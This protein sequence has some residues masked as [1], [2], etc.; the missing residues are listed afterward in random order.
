MRRSD[1][2][3]QNLCCRTRLFWKT[4]PCHWAT[5]T[6]QLYKKNCFKRCCKN[7]NTI[8]FFMHF[9]W[10]FHVFSIVYVHICP[11]HNWISSVLMFGCTKIRMCMHV[12]SRA[13]HNTQVWC[14]LMVHG[15]RILG[16]PISIFPFNVDLIFR[17]FNFCCMKTNSRMHAVL[18]QLRLLS[19]RPWFDDLQALPFWFFAR[20]HQMYTYELLFLLLLLL[21]LSLLLWLLLFLLLLLLL[22]HEVSTCTRRA[23]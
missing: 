9:K 4:R 3:L 23:A 14:Q 5:G 6:G 11:A 21:I 10:C 20:Q 7:A 16:F 22:F 13:H 15:P 17:L 2:G 1:K 12:A 19:S 18:F 8:L